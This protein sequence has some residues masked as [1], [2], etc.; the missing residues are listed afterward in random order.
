MRAVAVAW[1]LT[2][3]LALGAPQR[4]VNL[5]RNP[6]FETAGEWAGVGSGFQVDSQVVHSGRQ[7]L[8]C[9]GANLQSSAGAKQVITLAEPVHHPLRISAWSRAEN[10]VV[11]QDYN[12]FLDL[13]YTDGTPLWG[14][15]ARF[16]P[17]THGWQRTELIF[18]VAKPVASIE[19]HLLFRKA[20]GT[21]WFDDVTVELAPFEFIQPT[22]LPDV[23]GGGSLG[24]RATTSLP[25]KWSAVLRGPAGEL[26]RSAG[27]K[28]PLRALWQPA[29][30]VER[31][32]LILTATDDL[33]GETVTWQRAVTFDL[34]RPKL[35]YASWVVDSMARVQPGAFPPATRRTSVA[36]DAAGR[37]A[38]SFQVVLMPGPGQQLDKVQVSCSDLQRDGRTKLPASAVQWQQVGY[39][40]VDPLRQH[41]AEPDATPGWWPDALLPVPRFD[42]PEGFAQSVWFTITVPPGTPAGAYRGQVALQAA[43]KPALT[44][45]V[46]LT[47][48]PFDLPLRG[49]FKNT[50]ALM[51]GYLERLYGR[52]L[53]PTVRRQYGD[54]VLDHRLNPDDISRTDLPPIEDLKH[55][56]DR[57]MN[58]F[59]V[60]N[61]VRERGPAT[62]VCWSPL[63]VY[64]PAFKQRLIDRLDPYVAELRRE[65]LDKLAYIYTFDERG[66]EFWPTMREYFGLVRERW[67]LPT[68][69]TAY[70]PN[71]PARLAD[72]QIDWNCPLTPKYLRA[73]ADACRAAGRQVWAYVCMGPGYP[74]A[75]WLANH[76]LVESRVFC[77]QAWQEQ[78]DGILYWGLNI[79]HRAHNDKL[80]DPTAGP[81]LDWSISTG[82]DYAWLVGD[83][84]L[85]YAGKDGPIG[86]LRLANLRDGM[87]DYEYLWLA[88]AAQQGGPVG[89]VT[90]NLT[91]YT[92]D[93]ATVRAA[94]A[95]IARQIRP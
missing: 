1:L 83:G 53:S 18:E 34:Q 84:D 32:E 8:R 63:E 50:F 59:N 75:N 24:V 39:V 37:E 2:A 41:P 72:L 6:G 65:G 47:V 95:A 87:E 68:L 82:G 26:A 45:P 52:P 90:R 48:H 21:V 40:Q 58:C 91:D 93:P 29:A 61:M 71:D 19:V 89:Q 42:V 27:T 66:E 80:I 67:K 70:V 14:Q 10:A 33:L 28:A 7:A 73:E 78:M 11:G 4:G 86:S 51:D 12:L 3:S 81:L 46:E 22:V 94:R 56:R 64:T 30:P 62:W 49:H 5:V 16:E 31:A 54:F 92:R 74:Y 36:I 35:G 76:P 60:V 88:R 17:G 20:Q 38:E 77:W 15:I 13:H 85:L 69:T 25:A 9:Q 44:V 23:F 55:Y 43:G 57:G 79:W